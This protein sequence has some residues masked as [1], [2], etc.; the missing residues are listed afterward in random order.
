[1]EAEMPRYTVEA[2]RARIA[3]DRELAAQATDG[4]HHSHGCVIDRN[5]F[6]VNATGQKVA[7]ANLYSSAAGDP[8]KDLANARFIVNARQ[9]VE[10]RCSMIEQ[11]LDQ[12]AELEKVS[13]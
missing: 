6:M 5:G 12:I 3:V 9:S 7:Q 13:P 11:L 10:T 4:W 1:M 2:I 8:T